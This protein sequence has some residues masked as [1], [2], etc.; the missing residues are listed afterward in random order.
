M[1]AVFGLVLVL[2][3]GLAGFAVYMVKG[4]MTDQEAALRAERARAQQIVETVD[5][6]AVN[7]AMAYGEPITPEDVKLIKYAVE[8]LPEGVFKTEEELF[9]EGTDLPRRILRQIEP[10]EPLLL[11]KVTAPGEDAGINQRL[12]RGMRAFTINVDASSGVSG[13]LRPGDK[14]DVYW[15]GSVNSFDGGNREI[16]RLIQSGVEL[17]AVDQSA[18][19]NRTGAE[20]ARTVTVQ[21]S[22]QDVA[23]LAQAQSTGSL[24]LSLVGVGDESVAT[25]IEVDQMSLLGI[26]EAAPL[27]PVAVEAAPQACTIRTR[28]GAEL[29]DVVIPCTN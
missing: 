29:V 3:M 9:P 13:F 17:I 1:R 12:A 24:S 8:F 22:P 21:V 26:E 5:V 27:A 20:I 15:T 10:N 18:D 6:Y 2:G 14:V 23:G 19:A 16:T 25:A 11:T 4:Y 28:R 7:R